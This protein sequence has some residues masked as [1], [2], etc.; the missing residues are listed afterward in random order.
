[1]NLNRNSLNNQFSK[2]KK[3]QMKKVRNKKNQKIQLK[4]SKMMIINMKILLENNLALTFLKKI[5]KT[6][7]SQ[8]P[9]PQ[10]E[11][12]VAEHHV[13][14]Q[15]SDKSTQTLPLLSHDSNNDE[16][17]ILLKTTAKEVSAPLTLD[18][19]L[20]PDDLSKL[21]PVSFLDYMATTYKQQIKLNSANK[22][23]QQQLKQKIELATKLQKLIEFKCQKFEFTPEQYKKLLQNCT[24]KDKA[25]MEFYKK[26]KVE[27]WYQYASARYFFAV[28]ELKDFNQQNQK[29][30]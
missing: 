22:N 24:I 23:L 3:N 4:K 14:F 21:Q 8:L 13:F 25:L 17:Q 2:M 19:V 5:K 18:E 27:S 30:H 11:M 1:M 29:S 26:K 12:K 28:E 7:E 10:E 6:I 20:N 9:E 15:E 16:F